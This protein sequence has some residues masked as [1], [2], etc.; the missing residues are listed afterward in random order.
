MGH[1]RELATAGDER[2]GFRKTPYEREG[3][4][5]RPIVFQVP[6]TVQRCFSLTRSRIL[7]KTVETDRDILA[8]EI[9][10]GPHRSNS[11]H[12]IS[13]ASRCRPSWC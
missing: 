11:E 13:R 1:V 10:E 3:Y 7:P 8:A 4:M 12:A 9:S 2:L 5:R 6:V